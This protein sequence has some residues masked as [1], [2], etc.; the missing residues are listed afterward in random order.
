MKTNE[1]V[2]VERSETKYFVGY[3]LLAMV[4]GVQLVTPCIFFVKQLP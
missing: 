4:Q 1:L 3:S 2:E